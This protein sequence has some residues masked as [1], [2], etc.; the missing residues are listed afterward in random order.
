MQPSKNQ[1]RDD[2]Q[3]MAEGSAYHVPVLYHEVLEA[4]Q[5][6]PDGT[7]VDCTMGGGGHTAGILKQLGPT[8]SLVAFDQ[9]ADAA[10]N[11]PNDPRLLFVQENFRYLYRFLRLHDKLPVDGILADLGVSSHHFNEAERGF[12]YR[13]DGPLDM[14]MKKDAPITAADLLNFYDTQRLQKLLSE[15]GEVTNAK[16]LANQLV[17]ARKAKLFQTISDLVAV[18]KPMSKG[19]PH[20]YYAQVF[21]ALRIEVNDEMGALAELLD[22][23]PKVLKSGSIVA[24]ITFH[25]LEDR[26]VKRFFKTGSTLVEQSEQGMDMIYGKINSSP[27]ELLHKKPIE[28]GDEELK[29]NERS[30]SA[31]LRV[32][33][34][35]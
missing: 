12:S 3:K 29:R 22:Q 26:M 28:A 32:A 1:Y 23:L 9:D 16:T 21:Q 6:K 25:S 13:F 14:R 24:I 27:F 18:L 35:K 19:N 15:Y 31:R 34:F 30:R 17:E 10:A 11:L 8:G 7:Y 2:E 5:I 33:R 4:L 20:R